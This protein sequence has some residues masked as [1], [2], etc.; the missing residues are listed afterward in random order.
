M[1]GPVLGIGKYNRKE[2]ERS[3]FNGVYILVGEMEE[4]SERFQQLIK[5]TEKTNRTME[6]CSGSRVDG[7]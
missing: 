2:K 4:K 7:I 3:Y 1:P 5:V 6:H